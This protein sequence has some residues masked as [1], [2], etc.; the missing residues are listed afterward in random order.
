MEQYCGSWFREVCT[1]SY[2][3]SLEHWKQCLNSILVEAKDFYD[4]IIK[5]IQNIEADESIDHIVQDWNFVG[6]AIIHHMNLKSLFPRRQVI[7]EG[8]N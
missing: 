1:T 4:S 3:N 8:F 7:W 6:I 5:C 2:P